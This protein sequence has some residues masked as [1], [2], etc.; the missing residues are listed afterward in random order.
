MSKV[1]E[2]IE[3][4]IVR[5]LD[6]MLSDE[7]QLELDRELIRNPE[8]RRMMDEYRC[9]DELAAA[10][11]ADI[12]T[13]ATDADRIVA[14]A[15]DGA[16]SRQR[17]AIRTWM[18]IP[19]AIAAAI[20]AIAIPKPAFESANNGKSPIVSTTRDPLS[21]TQ[22]GSQPMTPR[23][24][25]SGAPLQTV[26]NKPSIRRRAGTEWTGVMGDDGNVYWIEVERSRTIRTPQRQERGTSLEM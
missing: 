25:Q 13:P 11:L 3:R 8:A 21:R 6:G 9:A 22:F 19:G 24:T 10:A 2:N 15:T 12:A 14:T 1:S 18:L 5:S 20:L 4:A 16:S 26:G 7:Q 17:R 23:G